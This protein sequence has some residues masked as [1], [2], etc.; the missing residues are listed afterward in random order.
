[1]MRSLAITTLPALALLWT[2]PAATAPVGEEVTGQRLTGGVGFVS[3][4]R[5]AHQPRQQD[6][7]RMLLVFEPSTKG[8]IPLYESRDDGERWRKIGELTEE[9]HRDAAKGVR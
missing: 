1:M 8:G 9:P 7:G 3:A 2:G 4:V 5:L 6:N